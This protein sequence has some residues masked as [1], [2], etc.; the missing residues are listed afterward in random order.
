MKRLSL[1]FSRLF[2]EPFTWLILFLTL[3]SPAVGLFWYQPLSTDTSLSLYLANPALAGGTAGGILFG[4]LTIYELDRPRRMEMESLMDAVV[5]PQT[6]ALLRLL[7][8]MGA[9]LIAAASAAVLWLPLCRLQVGSVFRWQDY[10][11]ACTLLMGASFPLA[12]LAA[13]AAFQFTGR[14]NLA[15]IGRAHV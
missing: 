3:L 8:L 5:A 9:A 12:I 13:A 4:I 14:S 11:L 2:R 15:Q 1:E 7:A 6:M 10:V